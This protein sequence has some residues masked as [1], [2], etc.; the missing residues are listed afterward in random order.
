VA[1]VALPAGAGAL[2]ATG[3]AGSGAEV[4]GVI[5]TPVTA[6]FTCF[7]FLLLDVP[8]AIRVASAFALAAACCSAVR[9]ALGFSGAS[10]KSARTSGCSL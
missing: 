3:D 9:L 7:F 10:P 5:S 4:T 1:P 6:P 2:G 8:R